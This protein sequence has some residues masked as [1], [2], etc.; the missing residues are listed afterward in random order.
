MIPGAP[1]EARWIR[2]EPR[3]LLAAPT[4]E[5][6]VRTAFPR[7][8]VLDALPLNDGF[9]NANFKV[10]LSTDQFVVV[11][12]YEHDPSLCQ[13][14]VDLIRLVGASVPVAEVLH[15][16]PAGFEDFPPFA[17]MRLIEGIS[18]RELKRAGDSDAIAEAAFSAGATLAAIGRF[19]FPRAGWLGPGPTVGAPLLE[20]ADPTPR[21]VD[22]CLASAKL[23]PRMPADLRERVHVL[24]W[25]CAAELAELDKVA[26]LVHGDFGKR[27]LLVRR[28]HG[29]WSVAAV[30]DWE[31]AIAACPLVDL[32]H[33]L[34]YE[35]EARPLVEPHF[36]NGYF[37]AG[38]TLPPN[39][40]R[41]AYLAD[42]TALCES[43]THEHLPD[44]VVTEFVE[45]VRATVENR[46]PRQP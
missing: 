26:S 19:K 27:N 45:L 35:R 15:A 11:R 2:P 43:L 16:E 30:L 31:F 38:G 37:H 42:M 5:R 46:D 4:L 1:D 20:G 14:E 7:A 33:F 44:A 17:V 6:L 28:D 12:I 13:K 24:L 3:R 32:G 9:R 34:R 18:F 25:S 23:Q 41:L 21:F 10:Q 8:H 40:R 22:L 39:W 29:R 36:S